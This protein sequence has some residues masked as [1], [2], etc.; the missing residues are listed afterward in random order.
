MKIQPKKP[1]HFL[2]PNLNRVIQVQELVMDDVAKI[3][4]NQRVIIKSMF[5][6]KNRLSYV[7]T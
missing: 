6:S 2:W 7:L 1:L 3:R 4:M 5:Y